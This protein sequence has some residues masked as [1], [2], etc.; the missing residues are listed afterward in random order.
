MFARHRRGPDVAARIEQALPLEPE[1]APVPVVPEYQGAD[2]D[3]AHP[4]P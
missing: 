3:F 1:P 2:G 4:K